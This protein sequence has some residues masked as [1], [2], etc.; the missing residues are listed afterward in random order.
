MRQSGRRWTFLEIAADLKSSAF[1][2]QPNFNAYASNDFILGA[3]TFVYDKGGQVLKMIEGYL[4]EQVL[5]G[6]LQ[7]YL[8]DFRRA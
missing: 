3:G 6:A 5:R 7:S 1:P 2:V 8:A 4:G